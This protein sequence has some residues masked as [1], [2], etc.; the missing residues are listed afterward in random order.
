MNQTIPGGFLIAIEGIDGAGK[1]LQAREVGRILRERGLNCILTHEPTNG[2][3]GRKLR[4]SAVNGR[5]S[6]EEE[7]QAFMEDRRQHV[8]EVIRPALSAGQIVITDRYYFSTVAYQGA[9][10]FDPNDLLKQNE[11]I[12]IEPNLLIIIDLDPQT[13]LARV[14][15]RDGR[16][17]DFET[18]T[19]QSKSRDIFLAIRKPYLV[20]LDGNT[21]PR[22][23]R[24][25]ILVAFSRFAVER[26][27]ALP[28]LTPRQRLNAILAI[29]G[30]KPIEE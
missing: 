5:L 21:P 30:A 14:G 24:D 22:E 17:N 18:I 27:A 4:E 3:W 8:D 6:P 20:R 16:T 11:T 13:A 7:L 19:Q 23:L 28:G 15:N 9:R 2:P 29:H 26:I 1:S 25:Q 12:A 10:G